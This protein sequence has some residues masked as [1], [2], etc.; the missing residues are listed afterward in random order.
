MKNKMLGMAG[1]LGST[2]YLLTIIVFAELKPGYSHFWNTVSELNARGEAHAIAINACYSISAILVMLFSFAFIL[3]KDVFAKLSGVFI[4]LCF[5]GLIY[6]NWFTPMDP[7]QGVRT[8][9]DVVHNNFITG[10][11]ITFLVSQIFAILYL[12]K[13][14]IQRVLLTA[15]I[16]FSAS[17]IFGLVSLWANINKSE[18]INIS[19]RG[20]IL[21]F[22][23][24]IIILGCQIS[25]N[26]KSAVI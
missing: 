26:D 3:K 2:T 21:A 10:L 19:E 17:L 7:W 14:K 8:T 6:M 25:R 24:W 16:L 9:R 12:L 22:L 23:I 15:S 1:I 5:S 13:G 4:F 18:V 11:V 20:W